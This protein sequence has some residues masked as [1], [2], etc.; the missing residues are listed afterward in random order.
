MKTAKAVIRLRKNKVKVRDGKERKK[1]K[2]FTFV[3]Q[4][5]SF[6][7]AGRCN[8]MRNIALNHIHLFRFRPFDKTPRRAGNTS[9]MEGK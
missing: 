3:V 1:K 5:C 6:E 7:A 8:A 4:T 9:I 2:L